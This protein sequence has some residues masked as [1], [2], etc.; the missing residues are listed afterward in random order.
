MLFKSDTLRRIRSG[1]ITLAFR[2][3]RRP[4][5]KRGGTLKTAAGLLGIDAV[6]EVSEDEI[7]DADAVQAGHESAKEV[8]ETLSE[9][10]EGKV[11]RVRFKRAGE[12]PRIELR[13]RK[14]LSEDEWR[15]VETR[16]GR[17]DKASRKGVRRGPA[18]A[19]FCPRG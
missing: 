11:F 14:D 16:L 13:Q 5:V 19:G 3:W 12:D 4:T 17:L 1:E 2:K 15:E 7:T 10:S 8:R 6:E 9:R 18:G